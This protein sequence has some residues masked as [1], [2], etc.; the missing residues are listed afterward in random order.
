VTET[1]AGIDIPDSQMVR[2]ATEL[3]YVGPMF[4]DLGLTPKYLRVDQRF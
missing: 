1:I 2:E 4:R 3:V